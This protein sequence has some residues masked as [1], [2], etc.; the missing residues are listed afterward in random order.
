MIKKIFKFL[1]KLAGILLLFSLFIVL[2][3]KWVPVPFTP[4]MAIRYFENPEEKIQHSWV[5][6]QDI[7]RHLQLGV[8]ASEDQN[9]VK[10]NGFDIE[11]IEKAIEDN[12]K[13]KRVRGASTI[14]QQT[15]KNVFLWPGRNWLRKGLEVYFTFLI[16]TFWSKERILEVYLNSIEMGR[17]IYGAEAAAQHW[18]NKSAAN[19]SVYE[20][21]AIAAVLP[22]PREYRANPASN[23]INQR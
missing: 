14:S 9:F 5:P 23:Y 21:A 4:L 15:A 8:I 3:F 1:L 18:F 17:G 6:R 20:A 7:S 22:N 12:Q 19:L 13:G 10:H 11:A 16:E 2:L